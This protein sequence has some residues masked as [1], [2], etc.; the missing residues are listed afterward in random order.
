MCL[1]CV[2]VMA[3]DIMCEDDKIFC[4][5]NEKMSITYAIPA[6]SSGPAGPASADPANSSANYLHLSL[7]ALRRAL[8]N[9]SMEL[10]A[11]ANNGNAGG[12]SAGGDSSPTV[13]FSGFDG[14]VVR[15]F[16]HL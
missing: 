14:T 8:V 2:S 6:F 4:E 1:F 11:T 15:T 16:R 5:L 7:N 10:P 13:D 12:D 9:M 3:D